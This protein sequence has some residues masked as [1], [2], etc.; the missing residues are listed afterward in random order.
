[1]LPIE[2]GTPAVIVEFTQDS[3]PG[4]EDSLPATVSL[5]LAAGSVTVPAAGLT[6]SLTASPGPPGPGGASGMCV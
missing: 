2:V 3:F 5:R 6:V 4:S 1:M